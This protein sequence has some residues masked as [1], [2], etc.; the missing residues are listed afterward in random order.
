MVMTVLVFTSV[1]LLG[2]VI[3]EILTLLV[4]GQITLGIA[5]QGIVLL[6]P[7]VL[8][9][10]LP[11]GMLTATLLVFGR[12]S[13]DQELTAARASGISL[14]S[15]V[16]PVLLLG[17]AAGGLCAWL[18]FHLAPASRVAYNQLLTSAG[19]KRPG[20]FLLPNQYVPFG[21]YQVFVERVA[22][23]G[24]HLKNVIV[25]EYDAHGTQVR[26]AKAPNGEM[27]I[28]NVARK[29][30]LALTNMTSFQRG[31]NGWF[32]L[33]TGDYPLDA[34][35]PKEEAYRVPISDMT[36]RQLL[37]ELARQERGMSTPLTRGASTEELLAARKQTEAAAKETIMP[38]LVYLNQQVV[39]SFACV[40]F[41]LIGIPLAVRAHRRETSIG[42]AIALVLVLV[43]YGLIALAQAWSTRPELY[44]CLIL[45]LPNFVFQAVGLVLLW[46]SDHRVA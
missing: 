16:G 40:G 8:A 35:L 44:P 26:W 36:F 10:S 23:D 14:V 20:G 7:Y 17:V 37:A 28:D 42:V 27:L 25:A 2:N 24:V 31:Q 4:N 3:K 21:K 22:P 33:I 13:A 32:P 34:D 1:L 9:F 29:I 39:F 30:I 43:Y 19:R 5:F 12:F 18:N 6:I 46:R 15:L 45:W 38:V 41:T 11:M